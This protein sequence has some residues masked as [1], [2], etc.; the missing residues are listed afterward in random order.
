MVVLA[1]SIL[2]Q[3]WGE[4][5]HLDNFYLGFFFGQL[6][7]VH[8]FYPTSNGWHAEWELSLNTHELHTHYCTF[9]RRLACSVL[10]YWTKISA[11][12]LRRKFI[13]SALLAGSAV[14]LK[15]ARQKK[16]IVVPKRQ[17]P[18]PNIAS[19]HLVVGCPNSRAGGWGVVGRGSMFTLGNKKKLP[20]KKFAK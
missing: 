4:R 17:Q 11:S 8:S 20:P 19:V 1:T 18:N 3:I 12:E 7:G 15:A 5:L 13:K 6:C 14:H 2:S 9:C 16:I 10:D